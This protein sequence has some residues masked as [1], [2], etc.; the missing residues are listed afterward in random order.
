MLQECLASARA[1]LETVLEAVVLLEATGG[2]RRSG[3]GPCVTYS[4]SYK[5]ELS[6]QSRGCFPLLHHPTPL[7]LREGQSTP[8]QTDRQSDRHKHTARDSQDVIAVR[9]GSGR[10]IG[11]LLL[12]LWGGGWMLW[13]AALSDPYLSAGQIICSSPSKAA[14]RALHQSHPFSIRSQTKA[15][16][17][18]CLSAC[19][20]ARARGDA[21][22]IA[23]RHTSKSP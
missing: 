4:G 12:G 16:L 22:Q 3:T 23:R 7:R 14:Q 20:S 10:C 9:V 5:P 8:P 21:G 6:G 19:L 18:A 11:L 1:V 15:R 17:S 13:R 2:A